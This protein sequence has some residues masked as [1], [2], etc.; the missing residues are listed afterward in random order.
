MMQPLNVSIQQKKKLYKPTYLYL[1]PTYLHLEP[2]NVFI[3]QEKKLYGH[4]VPFRKFHRIRV[5][6]PET[7]PNVKYDAPEE[8]SGDRKCFDSHIRK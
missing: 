8:V 6:P 1:E 7:F 5:A 2:S 4:I 3:Q